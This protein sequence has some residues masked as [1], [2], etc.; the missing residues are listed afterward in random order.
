MVTDKQCRIDIIQ[1]VHQG[2]RSNVKAV[3]CHRSSQ[4]ELPPNKRYRV[5]F[6]GILSLMMWQTISK[7][8]IIA[9]N[10]CQC[11]KKLKKN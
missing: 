7:T 4:E 8:A 1:N 2:S 6:I 11:Q 9:R 5:D 3:V 10:I